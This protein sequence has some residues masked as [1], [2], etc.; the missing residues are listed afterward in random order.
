[1]LLHKVKTNIPAI[2]GF[3]TIFSPFEVLAYNFSEHSGIEDT[4]EGSGHKY[5]MFNSADSINAGIATIINTILSFVGI[6]LLV[7]LV[8][9]GI[10]W[11]TAGGNEEQVTKAKGIIK[12]SLIGLLVV[13]FA[14]AVSWFVVNRFF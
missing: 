10:M 7:L 1:M 2:I 11:M 14:Y 3:L 6:L 9:A 4:A 5:T 8:Y 13:A 12:N